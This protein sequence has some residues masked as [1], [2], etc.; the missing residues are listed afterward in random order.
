MFSFLVA[1]WLVPVMVEQLVKTRGHVAELEPRTAASCAATA[2][3]LTARG[4]GA[5]DRRRR[6]LVVVAVD[7]RRLFPQCRAPASFPKIDEGGFILDYVASPGMSV[8]E[9]DRLMRQVEGIIR[10]TPDVDT[11]SRR[12]GLAARRRSHRVQHRGLFHPAEDR[13]AAVRSKTVMDDVRRRALA[14]V[15]GLEIETAQLME[16][17]IGDLTAVPQPIEVKLYA[18]DAALLNKHGADRRRRHREGS[19][20]HRAEERRGHRRRRAEHP[21]RSG[22]RRTGRRSTPARPANRSRRN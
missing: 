7:R 16:D 6:H 3:L 1:W 2:T 13:R 5:M 20:R 15:P 9:T 17:L 19:G 21:H 14:N 12:T 11:Y 10:A 8:T 18:D 22:P 4:A